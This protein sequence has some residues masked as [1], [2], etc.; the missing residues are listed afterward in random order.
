MV[1]RMRFANAS[2][3]R[4]KIAG[5][6]PATA[7]KFRAATAPLKSFRWWSSRL[8]SGDL[9][10]RSPNLSEE[11]FQDRVERWCGHVEEHRPFLDDDV[12]DFGFRTFGNHDAVG[13]PATAGAATCNLL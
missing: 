7:R 4:S 8:R 9:D 6:S 3:I 12:A 1:S 2:N 13:G 10:R 11:L 5:L